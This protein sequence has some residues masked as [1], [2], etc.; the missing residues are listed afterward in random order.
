MIEAR[1]VLLI[2]LAA[3]SVLLA[4]RRIAAGTARS[5]DANGLP[6]PRAPGFAYVAVG[7]VTNFF[8]TLGI[9]SFATTTTAYKV[10]RL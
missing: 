2:V 1:I 7:F 9:G 8:D 5:R 4:V 10:L 6:A 3:M